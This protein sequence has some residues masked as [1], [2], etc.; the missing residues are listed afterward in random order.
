MSLGQGVGLGS[1]PGVVPL[2]SPTEKTQSLGTR[3]LLECAY[4]PRFAAQ[5]ALWKFTGHLVAVDLLR[6]LT[7]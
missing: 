2:E 5:S 3:Y 4:G 1:T 7:V 6:L